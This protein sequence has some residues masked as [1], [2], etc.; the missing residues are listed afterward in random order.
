[1]PEPDAE[2]SAEVQALFDEL[3]RRADRPWAMLSAGA[4]KA[5]FARVLAH[6]C[7]A[8]ASGYLAGRAIWADA[9]ARFPDRAA[10]RAGL[11]GGSRAYMDTLNALVER[12]ARPWHAH[13]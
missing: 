5:E 4:G 8:G 10:M 2:G 7:R 3:G 9:F 12:Q 13:P 6:A 11:E 1:M